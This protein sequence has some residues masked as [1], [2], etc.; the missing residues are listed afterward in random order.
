[1]A[2]FERATV[3]KLVV[4][5]KDDSAMVLSGAKTT[6][7]TVL[8]ETENGIDNPKIGS[9]YLSAAGKVYVRVAA[10]GAAADWEKVTT[11]AA[12]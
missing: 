7:A 6:R 11:T 10:A 3:G 9:L 8:A 12:D 2:Q 5:T 1:M 4:T